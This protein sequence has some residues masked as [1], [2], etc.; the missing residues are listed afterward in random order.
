MDNHPHRL[1]L[2]WATAFALS[3]P[4]TTTAEIFD[5]KQG[6]R[7]RGSMRNLSGN[8]PAQSP[9]FRLTVF[10]PE[11][12]AATCGDPVDPVDGTVAPPVCHQLSGG[13]DHVAAGTGL[14]NAGFGTISV[15]GVPAGAVLIAARLFWSVL[16][17]DDT[18]IE[19]GGQ[20]MEVFF[21]GHRVSGE[22]VEIIDEL[23]WGNG[24]YSV[25]YSADV[26][27]LIPGVMN[28]DY[29]VTGFPSS[30]T[31]GSDPMR[32]AEVAALP[33][34]Q[35]VTAV[36][37]Y[38]HPEAVGRVYLHEGAALLA[39][40]LD[41]DL[42]LVPAVPAEGAPI[43]R[44]TRIGGDGQT[45]DGEP[46]PVYATYL[47]N[48]P[49]DPAE[50]QIRGPGSP[51]NPSPDWQGQDGAPIPG[52]WDT[53]SDELWAPLLEGGAESYVLRW[54]PVIDD[55]GVDPM[56]MPLASGSGAIP[57]KDG[58]PPEPDGPAYDCVYVGAV[59][60]TTTY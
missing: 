9:Y 40:G 37:I 13:F 54:A 60:M 19:D 47:S 42:E 43:V 24:G 5:D 14:R 4:A 23:C 39:D 10:D 1:S 41:L 16:A 48:G 27:R 36:L 30:V 33:L 28:G 18:A 8:P 6:G 2:L 20:F 59:A 51:V 50:L 7:R 31:D 22:R 11:T 12:Y 35:G 56:P 25:H 58:V 21:R 26:T 49:E 52:L 53:Q 32:D 55:G 44:H 57:L 45:W 46:L 17:G 38:S 34:A 15:R 29:P 3:I